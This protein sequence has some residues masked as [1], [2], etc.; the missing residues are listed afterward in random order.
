MRMSTQLIFSQSTASLSRQQSELSHVRQQIATGRSILTPSDD[1]IGAAAA[2][3]E[4]QALGV[5]QNHAANQ[6]AAF[7]TLS[8]TEST[9]GAFGDAMQDVRQQ[10]LEANNGAYTDADRRSIA[11]QLEN[12]RGELMG[13]ANTR[14]GAGSY[15][16]AGFS[17]GAPPFAMTS[18]G[19]SYS[20]DDGERQVE[21]AP[22][23]SMGVSANGAS[24]F[25]RIPTGN[26]VFAVAPGAGNTGD[27]IIDAGRVVNPAALTGHQYQ[28]NFTG[29]ATYDVV[30]VTLGSTVSSGNAYT[31]GV[32]INIAGMQT[33]ISGAPAA[34]DVFKMDPSQHQSV[35]ATLTSVINALK[36]PTNNGA[37]RAAVTNSVNAALNNLDRAMDTVL[38]ARTNVGARQAELARLQDI[39]SANEI[40]HQ[41]RLSEIQDLDY[42]K[43]ASD[44]AQQSTMIEANQQTFAKLAKLSLF[45]FLG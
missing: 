40:E 33:A 23:R 28:I 41:R 16:F 13:L 6:T 9:L 5:T 1:P 10:L 42:A 21:V 8:L 22:Q 43:A 18:T 31:S 27:G 32:A 29:A 17:D 44:V 11:T 39:T 19:A 35:F 36:T 20:G 7:A 24:T 15:L 2:L 37:D 14:D 45:N 26:G 12:L 3:K 38:T 34:G 30:D 4:S 25:M